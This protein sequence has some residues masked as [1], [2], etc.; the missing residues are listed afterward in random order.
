MTIT[1]GS[2]TAAVRGA[3]V[4]LLLGALTTAACPT[5]PPATAVPA[6]GAAAALSCALQTAP[7]EP[8]VFR[9]AV[10]GRMRQV[11]ATGTLLLDRCTS[12]D[13]SQHGVRSGRLVLSGSAMA[14]C[15][16]TDRIEGSGTITWYHGW[17]QRGYR[18]GVSHLRPAARGSGY[19]PADAFLSGG[20]VSGR[21]A[22]RR[23]RGWAVPTTDVT[24]CAIRGLRAVA[25]RGN[26]S[27]R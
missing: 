25:G 3:A 5:A 21:M 26:I 20:V 8:V 7:G 23:V 16:T 24:G 14:N 6:R 2:R 17:A 22:H 11:S 15:L 18:A 27:F 1:R 10:T 12:P 19:T 13:G 9:P 4:A